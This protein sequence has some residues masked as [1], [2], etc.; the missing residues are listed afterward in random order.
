M[1]P[2]IVTCY[3]QIV[4]EDIFSTELK[5]VFADFYQD[6]RAKKILQNSVKPQKVFNIKYPQS[7]N[8]L[9]LATEME[10]NNIP[11]KLVNGMS[12]DDFAKLPIDS[13]Y[14]HVLLSTTFI[15]TVE[16]LR[17]TVKRIRLKTDA[18][19]IVGGPFLATND[20]VFKIKE[21]DTYILGDGEK[22]IVAALQGKQHLG[23][24]YRD[25]NGRIEID[26]SRNIVDIN[27][28]H[29]INWDIFMR[30]IP[31]EEQE[32]YKENYMFPIETMRGCPFKCSFCNYGGIGHREVRYKTARRIFN[33]VQR[34]NAI[35]VKNIG[36]WDS[37]FTFPKSRVI[38]FARLINEH[39]L[40]HLRFNS[41][42]RI[43]DLDEEVVKSMK[44]AGWNMIYIGIESG[45]DKVLK[46]AN[47]GTNADMI[48]EKMALVQKYKIIP[49]CSFII[50]LP[51]E[52]PKSLQD[53][54]NLIKD[55]KLEYINLQV[56]RI[57]HGSPL[58][59]NP[60]KFDLT[61]QNSTGEVY[62]WQ[63]STMN[64]TEAVT[65]AKELFCRIAE[66]TDSLC[67]E[68]M[69]NVTNL[70]REYP[71]YNNPL[72]K[73]VLLAVQHEMAQKMKQR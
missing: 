46:L 52:T 36:I 13:E 39:N 43:T 51:G 45:N 26:G 67:L 23:V 28:T 9:I 63:H 42:A 47:K 30:N 60:Q 4:D 61:F 35:G 64:N 12:L 34:L 29:Y 25:K 62:Q 15:Y 68:N 57:R 58:Y 50:G 59:E 1:K 11:Y 65:Q 2:L 55:L 71:P 5:E 38:E 19:I 20:D 72:N 31:S 21:I 10:R 27:K 70:P 3:E 6:E 66:E 54:F 7:L 69:M 53:T 56:L 44:S 18:P 32:I 33:E 8:G 73:K 37:N 16:Q 17:K 49:W 41:Y 48:R 40:N 24:F 22:S 14:S